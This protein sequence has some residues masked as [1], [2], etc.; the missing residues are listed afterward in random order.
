MLLSLPRISFSYWR[1]A[2]KAPQSFSLTSWNIKII[3]Q[4]IHPRIIMNEEC[5][6]WSVSGHVSLFE[7]SNYIINSIFTYSLTEY[8]LHFIEC[9]PYEAY[10]SHW[11]PLIR[12]LSGASSEYLMYIQ[13]PFDYNCVR[14]LEHHTCTSFSTYML[15][16]R[17]II[18]P[19]KTALKMNGPNL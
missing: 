7:L 4:N 12:V 15:T 14:E 16:V 18:V 6:I 19:I 9:Q 10:Q 2:T 17:A 8:N 3:V 5:S 11:W 1:A 13:R